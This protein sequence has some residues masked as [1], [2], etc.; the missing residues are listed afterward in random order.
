M[1]KLRAP[2][3]R[4]YYSRKR[5]PFSFDQNCEGGLEHKKS[6]HLWFL[7]TIY[8]EGYLQS[9]SKRDA[10]LKS[11]TLTDP[12]PEVLLSGDLTNNNTESVIFSDKQTRLE[13][14]LTSVYLNLKNSVTCIDILI[15]L[16]LMF[17]HVYY[18]L[19]G[20]Y[21]WFICHMNWGITAICHNTLKPQ[22]YIYCFIKKNKMKA[23]TLLHTE[24]NL[25]FLVCQSVSV[26]SV[27]SLLCNVFCTVWEHDFW[28]E[29]TT[30][31]W[32]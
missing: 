27:S 25:L 21:D 7:F 16:P 19:R 12:L 26:L 2:K 1:A 23:G 10:F 20:K 3:N 28:R 29:S 24:S 18:M 8:V 13:S 6:H 32:T 5:F 17:I 30:A 14:R 9:C 15:L 22:N 11:L 31:C 4:G